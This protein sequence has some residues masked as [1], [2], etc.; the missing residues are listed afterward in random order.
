MV[1]PTAISPEVYDDL[2]SLS[3]HRIVEI[4][5]RSPECTELIKGAVSEVRKFFQVPEDYTVL[6]AGSATDIWDVITNNLIREKSFHF[7]N[8]NFSEAFYRCA[9]SWKGETLKSEVEWGQAND[10]SAEIPKDMELIALA[11]NETSS[12]VSCTDNDIYKLRAAH[13]KKLLAIDITSIAGVKKF[14]IEDADIWYFS[15]QKGLGLPSGLGVM[16]LSPE[17]V[18]KAEE[19]KKNGESVGCFKISDMKAIM[20]AKF[21][22]VQTPNILNLHLL[23]QQLTRWNNNGGVEPIEKRIRERATNIYAFFGNHHLYRPFVKEK[24]HRSFATISITGEEKDIAE[25]HKKA[26]AKDIKI[27]AGYGK[28]KPTTFRLANYPALQ[29]VDFEELFDILS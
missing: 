28:L 3:S 19:M 20:D 24:A 17:A 8:G 2:A 15:V 16:I 23:K 5:H 21:Q 9:K 18:E 26:E 4:S 10:F 1:G 6:F 13:P 12:C 14:P 27:S 25:A 22:T 29:W 11:Y 7:S